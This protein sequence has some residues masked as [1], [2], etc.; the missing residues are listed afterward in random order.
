MAPRIATPVRRDETASKKVFM[1][2]VEP[3]WA[4]LVACGRK[5]FECTVQ[6]GGF[7]RISIGC[8]LVILRKGTGQVCAVGIV[9]GQPVSKSTDRDLLRYWIPHGSR[10]ALD[11]YLAGSKSGT[12]DYVRFEAT[13]D[14]RARRFGIGEFLALAGL[15]KRHP[16]QP[17]VGMLELVG[18]YN[19]W[20]DMLREQLIDA[21]MTKH[22]L[23]DD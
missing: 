22:P 14:L 6:P 2:V 20:P 12:V 7:K 16:N 5:R 11:T 8:P 17:H 1:K 10:A 18:I 15:R 21:P 3:E 19:N 13:Y 23:S 4:E 9:A